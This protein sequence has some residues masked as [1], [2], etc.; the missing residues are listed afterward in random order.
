MKNLLRRAII[1]QLIDGQ[2]TPAEAYQTGYITAD[3]LGLFSYLQICK[4]I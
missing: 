4:I 2:I 3:E 1:K